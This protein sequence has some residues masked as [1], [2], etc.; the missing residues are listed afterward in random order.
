MKS[1]ILSILGGA[2]TVALTS[3]AFQSMP[4]SRRPPPPVPATSSVDVN[5]RHGTLSVSNC[6]HQPQSSL[7]YAPKSTS[8]DA[9]KEQVP[10]TLSVLSLLEAGRIDD[11]VGELRRS[12]DGKNETPAASTYHAVIEACCAGGFDKSSKRQ[13]KGA[14]KKLGGDRIK[15]AAEMLQLMGDG[16]TSHAHEILIS[17]YARRGRWQDAHK[18]LSTME[19]AFGPSKS[20]NVY[21]TVLNSLA[22]ANEFNRMNSL[23]IKMRREGVRPNIYLY[24]SLLKICASS[25]VP[26]WKE[27]R[28]ILSQCQR[29]PGV[30]PDIISYTTAM[31]ACARARQEGKALELFRAAKDLG[32]KLDVYFYTTAMDACAKGRSRDSWKIALS[33]LDEMRERGIE[34]N[35]VTYG[36][37]VTACGNG[38]QWRRALELLDA[39]RGMKLKINTITYNS[40]IAALAKAARTE[41]RQ[42]LGDQPN[43]E[44]DSLWQ[45]ALDLIKCMESE[46]VRRD[47]FTYSSAISACGMAGKWADAVCLLKAMKGDGIKPNK[48]AYTS[49]ITACANSRQWEPAYDLF[50]EMKSD[51]IRPDLVAYNALIGAGMTAEKP[52]EVYELWQEMCAPGN[53]MVSPDIVTLTEVIG[54]LDNRIGKANRERVDAVFLEAVNR[55]LILKKNSLDTLWEMD[56]S[57]LPLPVA[58]AACRYIFRRIVEKCVAG[59]EV[60]EFSLITG[61]GRTREYVREVLRDELKPAVYCVVADSQQGVLQVREKMMRNYIDGQA[62]F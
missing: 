15:M 10:S 14:S 2:G 57:K 28:S 59:E 39:M 30:D 38:G 7:A 37:A 3:S 34:P 21:Q 51:G 60:K 11:A 20:L 5:I 18:T 47:S 52:S 33:L 26:R 29:E 24:N 23:L 22:N 8:H 9:V 40:A 27:A 49:A 46:G 61:A 41:S 48:V 43:T 44:V 36:V 6:A 55:G 17:G 31:K 19:E 58:R 56:I 13:S 35:D 54:T 50:N 32:M 25:R 42:S 62:Q 1:I 4:S 45:K 12:A 16:A 53:D